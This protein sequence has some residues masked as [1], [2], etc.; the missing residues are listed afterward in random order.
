MA[1]QPGSGAATAAPVFRDYDQAALD[2]QLNLRARWPEHPQ[3][4]ERWAADSAAIRAAR[5]GELDLAYGSGPEEMLDL[6]PASGGGPAS[7]EGPVALLAFI[8]G[9]YWQALDKSDYSYLAPP[10]VDRGIAF[11]SLNYSLAPA[12]DI[13]TMIGQVRRALAWL[14]KNAG[15]YGVDPGRIIVAGHSAGGHLAAMA[16]STD[17]PGFEAG[18]P[19]GLLAGGCSISGVYDLEPVRLSYHNAVLKVP[20]DRAAAWSPLHALPKAA[21]PLIVAVGAEET[22]EFRRQH[23]EYATSWQDRGLPLVDVPLPGRHHFNAV[24]ALGE[25]NHPLYAAVQQLL[26]GQVS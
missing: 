14:H 12:A 3:F 10:F 26:S 22:E 9:G 23:A 13:G 21:P 8:H 4:F 25:E 1:S 16:L 15:A 2:A 20:A 19:V 18:L 7:G 5:G 24:D 11:A 6:F 17:W